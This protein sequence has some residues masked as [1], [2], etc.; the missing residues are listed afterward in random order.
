[1]CVHNI[2]VA[3]VCNMEIA[4]VFNMEVACV[5]ITWRLHV[6]KIWVARAY[7]INHTGVAHTHN[8]Q[9]RDLG[10]P[11]YSLIFSAS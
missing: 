10:K 8:T 3:C 1:M 5:C 11:N 2:D 9:R 7:I 6:R 4:C